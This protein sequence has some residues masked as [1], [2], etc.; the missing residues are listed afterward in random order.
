M[1]KNTKIM[2]L[3]GVALIVLVGAIGITFAYLSTGGSQEQA[4]TFNSG[5]LSISLTNESASINLTSAYPISDIEGLGTTSYD[6]TITNN[7][8]S[9]TNYQIN[10]ESLNQVSN[11]LGADYIKVSLSSD[12]VGNVISK[13]SDNTEVTPTL[14][15]AYASHNLYITSIGANE[16]KTYHLKLWIDYDATVAEAANKTYTSKINVI[17]NP[18]TKV[19]DTL[20]T[21]FELNDTTLT[22]NLTDNVIS[23][24]YCTSTNNICT[25]NTSASISGNSYNVTLSGTPTTKQV[26]TVIGNIDVNT[27]TPQIVCTRLNG[28]SKVICSNPEEID[29]TPVFDYTSE[30]ADNGVGACYYNGEQVYNY[31]EYD[32]SYVT[33]ETCQ[34]VYRGGYVENGNIYYDYIDSTAGNYWTYKG[35]GEWNGST[36]TFEGNPVYDWYN[37]DITEESNCGAVYYDSDY[38]TYYTMIEELGSGTWHDEVPG[39]TGI[40]KGQDD[41]GATYYWRGNVDNNW[42]SF[43]GYYWRIIRINGDGSIRLIYS[44]EGSPQ[45]TGTGT[46]I[47][48]SE[49]NNSYRNNMYVGYMYTSGNVHGTGTSST[50]K[51]VLDN[52]YLTNI[53]NKGY[54]GYI[55]TNAGFCGDR[56]IDPTSS[57]TGLGTSS[58][59]Y[60]ADYR[61]SNNKTPTFGC[62]SDSDLYTVGS[63]NKGNKAL[64]YPVGL[65]TADEVAYAGG[66]YLTSNNS[67]HLYTNQYYWTMSPHFFRSAGSASVFVVDIDGKLVNDWVNDAFGVRPVINI[68]PDVRITGSGTIQDPYVVQT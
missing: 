59:D 33:E 53:Q 66:V 35:E 37:N 54:S 41:D 62:S 14:D 44:G 21:T 55:D 29:I 11:T 64:T 58:T 20:E 39:K 13:L 56:S 10:L 45:T 24:T 30:Q 3:A 47:G 46:Q 22:A 15:G 36:C 43:A 67:Y 4:N 26:A 42:V 28:T 34:R 1:K 12:T 60:G 27:S 23:A 9:S 8:N 48:T 63:S 19:I 52:W 32:Y 65:I 6:F 2:I 31:E 57:G 68:S 38:E 40:Y 61:L 5:C 50:I 16:S 17:A 25:P 18:E 49:F 51:G 7:C